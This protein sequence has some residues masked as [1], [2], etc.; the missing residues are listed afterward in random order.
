MPLPHCLKNF[1]SVSVK[2]APFWLSIYAFF[3]VL[4]GK[5]EVCTKGAHFAVTLPPVCDC[6]FESLGQEW[7]RVHKTRFGHADAPVCRRAFL[8]ASLSDAASALPTAAFQPGGAPDPDT[9]RAHH[10]PGFQRRFWTLLQTSDRS[11]RSSFRLFAH[12]T[13][14]APLT[15]RFLPHTLS[16]GTPAL[17]LPKHS[18][19]TICGWSFFRTLHPIGVPC[20]KS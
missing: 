8:G 14:L 16:P 12:H 19:S 6:S 11:S 1:S 5:A 7:G 20:E 18:Q 17:L 15:N 10:P 2:W 3:C 9:P 4:W 13:P